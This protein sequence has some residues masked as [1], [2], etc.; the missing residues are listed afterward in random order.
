VK[1]SSPKLDRRRRTYV[2]MMGEILHALNQAL[3]EEHAKRGLTISE[4]AKI[5]GKDTSYKSF[6]SR[7]LSGM[8]NMTLETLADLAFAMNRPVRVSLPPREAPAMSNR[9]STADPARVASTP[10]TP[11]T[12]SNEPLTPGTSRVEINQPFEAPA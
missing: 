6:I 10:P 11:P 4:I 7:K 3:A 1:S 5:L 8:S 12:R 2:R 9:A